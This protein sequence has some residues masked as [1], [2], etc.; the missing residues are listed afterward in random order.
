MMKISINEDITGG[1][2]CELMD[3]VIKRSNSLSV[4]RYYTG[5]LDVSEFKQMQDAYKEYIYKEDA[6]RRDDYKNNLNDYQIRINS[7]LHSDEGDD[8]NTYFEEI[9]EQD[10]RMFE[11]LQYDDFSKVPDNRFTCQSDEFIKTKYTRFTPVSMNP[12]FEMCFFQIGQIGSS[13]TAKMIGLF[14][15]PYRIDGVL[16]E[17]LTFYDENNI[18]LAVCSHERFAYLN[19]DESDFKA[20]RELG[21]T[22]E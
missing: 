15:F 8:A 18:V 20:F 7:M 21:I 12:V 11:E 10:L 6:K 16:F 22:Y 14:D 9:L 1:K 3:F 19:M 5:F 2:L 4:S 13:V 17:D